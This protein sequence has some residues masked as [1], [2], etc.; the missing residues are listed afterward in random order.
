MLF[1]THWSRS[2]TPARI[3]LE[4]LSTPWWSGIQMRPSDAPAAAPP[5]RPWPLLNLPYQH[6]DRTHLSGPRLS[7]PLGLRLWLDKAKDHN[8][9]AAPVPLVWVVQASHP[10][11]GSF[12][13]P[14]P[15]HHPPPPHPQTNKVT[16]SSSQS[17]VKWLPSHW[18]QVCLKNIYH[19]SCVVLNSYCWFLIPVCPHIESW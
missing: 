8:V 5:L 6:A 13:S 19:F 18:H 2:N 17:Q 9:P 4:A 10:L 11:I 12:P 7:G 14:P 3:H 15:H 16:C 1:W